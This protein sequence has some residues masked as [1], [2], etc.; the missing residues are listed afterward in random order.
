[1]IV[2]RILRNNCGI[3]CCAFSC[4][5]YLLILVRISLS[6]FTCTFLSSKFYKIVNKSFELYNK[7]SEFYGILSSKMDWFSFI[8]CGLI[9]GILVLVLLITVILFISF[10]VFL[11]IRGFVK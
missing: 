4:F 2:V 11:R 3:R 7:K 6:V 1:M 5:G 9:W 8:V 10:L